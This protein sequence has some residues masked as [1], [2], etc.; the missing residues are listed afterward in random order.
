MASS[1]LPSPHQL[2]SG[3]FMSTHGRI[4]AQA[5]EVNGLRGEK[6]MNEQR[7]AIYL[8]LFER[9]ETGLRAF[10][11]SFLASWWL[12]WIAALTPT[13][14]QLYMMR[15]FLFVC[16]LS[17]F[18]AQTMKYIYYLIYFVLP[19]ICRIWF[20]YRRLVVGIP[21]HIDRRFLYDNNSDTSLHYSAQY[22]SFSPCL[23]TSFAPPPPTR[24]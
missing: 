20:N 3:K 16:S 19:P 15:P 14:S 13:R 5:K 2:P 21:E 1:G 10:F 24:N 6:G 11:M 7:P 8:R 12:L 18:Y 23:L 17:F 22:W 4:E 9:K